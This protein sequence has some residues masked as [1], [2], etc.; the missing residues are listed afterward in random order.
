MCCLIIR[1]PEPS[2][3]R[4]MFVA[5]AVG[6]AFVV[7]AA[8]YAADHVS[9]GQAG[10]TLA[11]LPYAIGAVICHQ[12][13]ERSFALW[14]HQLPVCARCTGLYVGTCLAVFAWPFRLRL[15]K[16][17]QDFGPAARALSLAAIPSIATLAYEWLTGDAP[18]N[19]V[20][21]ISAFPLGAAIALVVLTAADD[22]VN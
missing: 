8:P 1:R 3:A 19:A 4:R 7:V 14:G 18:S 13:P 12:R 16:V 21:A 2:I 17:A 20:R 10:R 9:G 15:Q 5:A 22:R 6:W 11:A